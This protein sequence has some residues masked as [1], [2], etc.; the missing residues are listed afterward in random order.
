VNRA[1]LLIVAAAVLVLLGAVGA[2]SALTR[3]S[4]KSFA[5]PKCS[6]PARV[7]QPGSPYPRALPL[8]KGT[9]FSTLARYPN[10]IIV[11][12]R[13]P[14]ELLPATRFFVNELPRKGFRLGSAE[15]EPGLESE[16]DFTGHGVAGRFKVRKLPRCSGATTLVLAIARAEKVVK[17]PSAPVRG[18]L[19]A[20][21]G[22]GAD[23][24]AGLPRTFP[25]PAGTVVRSSR[26][27][28]IRG[29]S[30]R[31][32]SAL[33]PG[34]S[35]SAAAFIAGTLPRAGY[36]LTSAEREATEA[37]GT[38]AGRGIRGRV[39]FRPLFGCAGVLTVDIAVSR[40]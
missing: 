9:V 1:R 14:L 4:K 36:R 11:G 24:A 33:A 32:V 5:L 12:G 30:F 19:P 7:I 25:L 16:A 31:F 15:S 39:R 23:V 38:F 13:A 3:D 2:I 8:P 35:D 28:T 40:A 22:G 26:A 6:P 34:S 37:E 20:C 27:Q 10:V 18:G 21:A 17:T 29:R